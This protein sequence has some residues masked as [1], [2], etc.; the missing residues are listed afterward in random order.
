MSD[1]TGP[2]TVATFETCMLAF[3]VDPRQRLIRWNEPDGKAATVLMCDDDGIM[4][5]LNGAYIERDRFIEG[6]LETAEW[7]PL[8]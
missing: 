1:K 7:E 3:D 6:T 8:E 5:S 2:R 4:R